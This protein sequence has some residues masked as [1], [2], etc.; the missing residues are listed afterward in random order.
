MNRRKLRMSRVQGPIRRELAGRG[1]SSA[2]PKV[3]KK[4]DSQE[5]AAEILTSRRTEPPFRGV[6]SGCCALR[7]V[8]SAE[9]R[10]DGCR[11]IRRPAR[12]K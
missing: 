3:R 8:F 2:Q 7:P 5:T 10:H 4:G 9:E 1:V 11:H 12:G 6:Q